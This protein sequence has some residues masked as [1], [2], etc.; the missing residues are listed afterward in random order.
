MIIADTQMMNWMHEN[1]T[2]QLNGPQIK[3]PAGHGAYLLRTERLRAP[4]GSRAECKHS[5]V[6]NFFWTGGPFFECYLSI[7]RH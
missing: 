1:D 7:V 3:R 4:R 6:P 2:L 5:S